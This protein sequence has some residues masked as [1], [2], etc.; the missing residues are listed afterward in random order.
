MEIGVHMGAWVST[1]VCDLFGKTGWLLWGA[2][3]GSAVWS[4]ALFHPDNGV[5][6]T[7]TEPANGTHALEEGWI[8]T[9]TKPTFSSVSH[10]TH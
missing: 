4:E 2:H 9:P 7:A 1:S 6:L 5:S 8:F 3:Y 10:H